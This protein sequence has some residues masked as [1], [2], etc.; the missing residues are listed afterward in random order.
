MRQFRWLGSAKFACAVLPVILAVAPV[1]ASADELLDD[2]KLILTNGVSTVEGTGGGGLATWATI[3]GKGT[4]RS[5][6][7][8]G[9]VTLIEL[10]DYGLQS[11][12][13]AVGI[14]DRVELAYARQN[15][16]TR[17]VGAALGLGKGFTFNQD[18]FSAKVRLAGDAVYGDPLLPQIS[19]GAEYKRN[20]DGPVVRA[21]GARKDEDAEFTVSATKLFLAQSLLVNTTFRLTRANQFGLLGYGGNKN[22]SR[23]VQFEG[24]L[25]YMLS[26]RLVVGGEYRTKPDNLAIARESDA[27]DVFVAY[28]PTRNVTVTAA[29]VDLGSIATFDDQRG[30]FLSLQLAY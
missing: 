21:V 2:G 1:C 23:E 29:Y 17:K 11:H 20:L 15:F 5:L 28:A 6:G 30:G 7:I 12:G 18:V 26:P 3:S 16:D 22:G 24:S 9:H 19:I 14:H 13:L 8:S 25:A 10:P 27:H 4:D